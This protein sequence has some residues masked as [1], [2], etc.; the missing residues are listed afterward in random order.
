MKNL[1]IKLILITA[2]LSTNQ[3]TF[4][5]LTTD[6]KFLF[7]MWFFIEHVNQQARME[8]DFPM[9]DSTLFSMFNSTIDL[10][11]DTL[12][13]KGFDNNFIFLSVAKMKNNMLVN[14]SAITYN[15]KTKYLGYVS[16]PVYNCNDL[17]Y[18]L[19]VNSI[20]GKSYRLQGFYGNDFFSLLQEI[21][22][23]YKKSNNKWLSTKSFLKNYGVDGIDFECIYKGLGSGDAKDYPCLRSCSDFTITIH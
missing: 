18:V 19:C 10:K 1:I 21:K 15:S 14:D 20:S 5:Q 2:S 12:G 3:I 4:C 6:G 11:M 8:N 13:K 22:E 9:K 23:D 7:K 16:I 17:G